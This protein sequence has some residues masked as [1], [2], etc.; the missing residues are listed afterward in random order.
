MVKKFKLSE[1]PESYK[2]VLLYGPPG[3]GKTTA[4]GM[5][6]GKTLIIDVDNGTKVLDKGKANIDIAQLDENLSDLAELLEELEAD[7][8]YDNVCIDSISELEKALL[9]IAGR[10]GKNDGAPELR[11]YNQVGFRVVDYCRRL[12]NVKANIVFTAWE[13]LQE[14]IM[15]DG[16]KYNQ[17]KPMMSGKTGETIMGLC[18]VVGHLEISSKEETLGKRFV[19]LDATSSCLAKDRLDKRVYCKVEDLL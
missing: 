18:D 12:R 13:Q 2:T 3:A 6:K 8:K 19:R 9:T 14:Y 1:I 4:L 17:A 5:L 10:Y 11:H 15:A 16:S 7:C